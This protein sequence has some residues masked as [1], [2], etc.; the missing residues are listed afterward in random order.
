MLMQCVL[1]VCLVEHF[2]WAETIRCAKASG[3]SQAH[4]AIGFYGLARNVSNVLYTFENH[5]FDVLDRANI[6]YDVFSVTMSTR[7]VTSARDS[8]RG[9]HVSS[10]PLDP[11]DIQLLRPCRFSILDQE[12]VRLR[13]FSLLTIARKMP[14]HGLSLAKFQHFDQFNDRFESVKNALCS[15][16]TQSELG[17]MIT[18]QEKSTGIRYDAI[19]ALRP[20][21][22]MVRDID[23]PENLAA[24][25]ENNHTLWVPNFQ[26]WGGGYNDRLAYGSPQAMSVYLERGQLFRNA[27][28]SFPIAEKLVRHTVEARNITVKFSTARVLR[29]RQDRI[30]AEK[31]QYM[32]MGEEEWNRCVTANKLL[33]DAC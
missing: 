11:Y 22:A 24:I 5:V 32:G 19:L 4:I 8:T 9:L 33:S 25:R 29:V 15:Y 13:E 27:E 12:S 17:V 3:H 10:G 18:T 7:S 31:K 21:T 16:Y 20:D 14:Q 23:L 2:V 1:W 28:G 6:T 30:V 26:H